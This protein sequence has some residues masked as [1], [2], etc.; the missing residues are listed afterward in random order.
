MSDAVALSSARSF[1]VRQKIHIVSNTYV[2]EGSDGALLGYAQQKVMALRER[3]RFYSDEQKTVELFS[4][5]ARN[6]WDTTAVCDVFDGNGQPIGYFAKE[7]GKS[8]LRSAWNLNC[9]AGSYHGQERSQGF[10]ILRRLIEDVPNMY[11]FDFVD[12]RGEQ[13]FSI[14]AKFAMRDTYSVDIQDEQ[15][16][17]RVVAAMAV[18][19]DALQNR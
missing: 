13:A 1:I 16:D 6:V 11:N 12:S 18:A 8:L 14:N 17:G 4:F 3:V 2:I 15:I 5:Q 7:F 10:A 19:L 9:A